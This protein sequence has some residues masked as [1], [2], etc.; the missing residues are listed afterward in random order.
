MSDGLFRGAGE[1]ECRRPFLEVLSTHFLISNEKIRGKGEDSGLEI[2]TE[3]A[4]IIGAFDGCGGL[5]AKSCP[6]ISDKTEAYVAS[7]G[8]YAAVKQWFDSNA[9]TGYRWDEAHLKELILSNL[10]LCQENAGGD[11]IKFRGTLFRPF[12]STMA[13]TTFRISGDRL[14]TEHLWAGDSRT[15]YLDRDGLCQISADD[16]QN[17][18]A[19]SN[20]SRDGALTN[21]ISADGRFVLHRARFVPERP[22]MMFCAT[23]GC[24]GYVS[25]PMEFEWMLLSSLVRAKSVGQ[26]QS[27]L[28]KEIETRAGD[29]QTIAVA[30]FGYETFAEMRNDYLHRYNEISQV[31]QYFNEADSKMKQKMWEVYKPHYYKFCAKG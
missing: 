11:G 7:R 16:I 20:L 22:C 18:D 4:G 27:L 26:W 5:G 30:A 28:N 24:F 13:V 14:V 23:D 1:L 31:V 29:D 3:E 15:Y 2:Y 6:A 12:P 19:M 9:E 21:V 8:I 17:E 25:S 10:K